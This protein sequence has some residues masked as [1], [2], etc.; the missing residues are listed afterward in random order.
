MILLTRMI[1]FATYMAI[2]AAADR[3]KSADL[4]PCELLFDKVLLVRVIPMQKSYALSSI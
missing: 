1:L 2:K 4:I 3:A